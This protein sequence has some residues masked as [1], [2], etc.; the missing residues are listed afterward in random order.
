M[1]YLS[2]LKSGWMNQELFVEAFQEV[3][4]WTGE[5]EESSLVATRWTWSPHERGSYSPSN[6]H[7]AR[8]RMYTPHSSH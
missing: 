4:P 7:G 1:P 6:I 8:D 2:M 3:C 5:C